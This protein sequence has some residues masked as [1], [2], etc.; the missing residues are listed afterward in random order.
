[1][2]RRRRTARGSSVFC[3]SSLSGLGSC[4]RLAAAARSDSAAANLTLWPSGQIR[5]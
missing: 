1:M 4:C 2:T 5:F 3:S